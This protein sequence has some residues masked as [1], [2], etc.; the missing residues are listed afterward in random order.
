VVFFVAHAI[1]Q[2]WSADQKELLE[3]LQRGW[4]LW[5]KGEKEAFK[6]TWHKDSIYWSSFGTPQGSEK[7]K[8]LHRYL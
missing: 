8:T 3:G 2:E 7:H 6:A 4:E 5:K 1:G